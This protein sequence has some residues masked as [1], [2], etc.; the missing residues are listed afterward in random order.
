MCKKLLELQL[1][2][3]LESQQHLTLCCYG[4]SWLILWPVPGAVLKYL[5]TGG[6]ENCW[7][8]DWN[9]NMLLWQRLLQGARLRSTGVTQHSQMHHTNF[10]IMR[11]SSLLNPNFRTPN[12]L[13]ELSAM[14]RLA[15]AHEPDEKTVWSTTTHH[16]PMVVCWWVQVH[17]GSPTICRF[18]Y[19][20]NG[21]FWIFFFG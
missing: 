8:G 3:E 4:R 7:N 15:R 5:E 10:R 19:H 12:T 21:K 2:L 20:Q 6:T 14:R 1:Q 11:P 18:F 9:C 16:P 13:L 17:S